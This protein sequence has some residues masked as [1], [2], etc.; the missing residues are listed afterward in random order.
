[1]GT[2]CP[3]PSELRCQDP[4]GAHRQ[5]GIPIKH[6]FV[7]WWSSS[8]FTWSASAATKQ[9]LPFYRCWPVR[10]L[11][12]LWCPCSV[13]PLWRLPSRSRLHFILLDLIL[14]VK[15]ARNSHLP[16]VKE[17]KLRIPWP[18]WICLCKIGFLFIGLCFSYFSPRNAKLKETFEIT[19]SSPFILKPVWMN[20]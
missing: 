15:P 2:R 13:S 12:S 6:T 10:A 4:V 16:K 19:R 7:T 14:I 8:P 18:S 20:G 1:M 9:P 11:E 17:I 5:T 3:Y